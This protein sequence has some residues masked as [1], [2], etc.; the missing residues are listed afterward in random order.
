MNKVLIEIT[1]KGWITSIIFNNIE[2]KEEY[3]EDSE[4]VSRC[5]SGN[6]EKEGLPKEL[7]DEVVKLTEYNVMF[8]LKNFSNKHSKKDL[9]EYEKKIGMYKLKEY[10][11]GIMEKF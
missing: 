7:T 8:A 11:Q 3:E 6:L 4:G 9:L 5:I 2:Y 10:H 1:E